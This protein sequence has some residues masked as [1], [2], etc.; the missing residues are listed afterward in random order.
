MSN[1]TFKLDRKGVS[2]LMKSGAMQSI[3][4]P[5]INQIKR[6]MTDKL[7]DTNFGN[8]LLILSFWFIH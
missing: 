7:K 4:N 6:W 3:L 2:E 8:F 5:F 1:I